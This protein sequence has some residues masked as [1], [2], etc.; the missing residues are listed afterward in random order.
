MQY[1]IDP[2]DIPTS[3]GAYALSIELVQPV[4][5]ARFPDT[6]LSAG[7]YV[8]CGSAYGPG[9]LRARVARHLRHE[10]PMRWHVD[11]LTRSGSVRAVLA[12]PEGSECA[13][14]SSIL[15]HPGA[16]VPI[17]GFG[18]SDCRRCPAHLAAVPGNFDLE[19]VTQEEMQ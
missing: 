1:K 8:Y 10:K 19:C 5:L 17:R 18:S 7:T 4:R 13:L 6:A 2:D 14:L 12:L 15:T 3:A 16:T 9:G 11:Y